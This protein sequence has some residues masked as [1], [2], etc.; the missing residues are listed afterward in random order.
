MR[1]RSTAHR[2]NDAHAIRKKKPVPPQSQSVKEAVHGHYA[3]RDWLHQAQD[4]I[5]INNQV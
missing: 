1:T 3:H 5:N 4:T 2:R